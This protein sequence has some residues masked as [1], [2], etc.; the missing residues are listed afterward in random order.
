VI[1]NAR[2]FSE[3]GFIDGTLAEGV[4]IDARGNV[5]TGEVIPRNLKKFERSGGDPR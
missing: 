5:Y 2:D 4:T 3:I 1:A